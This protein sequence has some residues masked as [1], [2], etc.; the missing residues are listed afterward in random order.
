MTA[1]VVVY[2]PR[3]H[4]FGSCVR[5]QNPRAPCDTIWHTSARGASRVYSSACKCT[6]RTMTH[7]T[8]ANGDMS[9]PKPLVTRANPKRKPARAARLPRPRRT[10]ASAAPRGLTERARTRDSLIY[11]CMTCPNTMPRDRTSV[12]SQRTSE[13]RHALAI[14]RCD[15]LKRKLYSSSS[16]TDSQV[17]CRSASLMFRAFP[18]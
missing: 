3:R 11:L 15:V 16:G 9:L 13:A 14:A 7:T 5:H 8:H 10:R 17:Q 6:A 12:H 18:R 1:Q 2:R 4:V